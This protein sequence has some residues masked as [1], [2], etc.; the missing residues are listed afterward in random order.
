MAARA[1]FAGSDADDLD[2]VGDEDLAVADAAGA[3]G[4]L[5]GLDGGGELKSSTTTSIL[6]FGRKSTTYSAPR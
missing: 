1:G 2:D 3:G 6:I 5:D 4:R